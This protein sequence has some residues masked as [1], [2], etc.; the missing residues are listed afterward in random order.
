VDADALDGSR[1]DPYIRAILD[2][3]GDGFVT[4]LKAGDPVFTEGSIRLELGDGAT[5]T[6]RLGPFHSGGE[7]E[8][9]KR[10]AVVSDSPYVYTLAEWTVTRL[11]RDAA[12]FKKP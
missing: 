11:F 6:I 10:T 5:R 3:E 2:A 9:G 12:Y 7:G 8:A 1:I 4:A